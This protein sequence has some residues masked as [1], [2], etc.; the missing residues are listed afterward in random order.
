MSKV[1]IM[2][3]WSQ[4]QVAFAC[5]ASDYETVQLTL[6]N[7]VEDGAETST[8]YA[9]AHL[10]SVHDINE[11]S[12]IRPEEHPQ[13]KC[14][15]CAVCF[16]YLHALTWR[17]SDRFRMT[18][19]PLDVAVSLQFAIEHDFITEQRLET[20]YPGAVDMARSL[21][22]AYD[23]MRVLGQKNW[24]YAERQIGIVYPADLQ[25]DVCPYN[26]EGF[27][28]L[29]LFVSK[30]FAD[31]VGDEVLRDCDEVSDVDS[32]LVYSIYQGPDIYLSGV[33][34]VSFE[35]NLE[36]LSDLFR[37]V[38]FDEEMPSVRIYQPDQAELLSPE[39]SEWMLAMLAR[40]SWGV[41]YA[42]MVDEKIEDRSPV[43]RTCDHAGSV[44]EIKEN[45][46]YDNSEEDDY[47]QPDSAA[48]YSSSDDRQGLTPVR[49]R[50]RA[51]SLP[52]ATSNVYQVL[53]VSEASID[54]EDLDSSTAESKPEG[55]LQSMFSTVKRRL[56]TVV[57]EKKK[58]E[59]A[60]DVQFQLK[61]AQDKL[62]AEEER[63]ANLRKK[64][65]EAEHEDTKRARTRQIAVKNA[66]DGWKKIWTGD[67]NPVPVTYVN[68][69]W[70]IL[71]KYTGFTVYKRTQNQALASFMEALY[72]TFTGFTFLL[73]GPWFIVWQFG[74][75]LTTTAIISA[76]FNGWSFFWNL[77]DY[78]YEFYSVVDIVFSLPGKLRAYYYVR[79]IYRNE[80]LK[81]AL[82]L[83]TSI[84]AIFVGLWL[85][86][87]YREQKKKP[88]EVDAP[89]EQSYA[90]H[91][92][93]ASKDTIISRS[94]LMTFLI[95]CASLLAFQDLSIVRKTREY[96]TFFTNAAIVTNGIEESC[97]SSQCK[98][99]QR[100]DELCSR[101]RVN[102]ATE[103]FL[104]RV[105]VNDSVKRISKNPLQY[106]E[107]LF[108]DIH[109]GRSIKW[110]QRLPLGS[111]V[112]ILANYGLTPLDL[113]SLRY[114]IV[115][116]PE[117]QD[118]IWVFPKRAS[119]P[120]F[121]DENVL[122]QITVGE[123]VMAKSSVA[124]VNKDDIPTY[125]DAMAYVFQKD[126]KEIIPGDI[127]VML[128]AEEIFINNFRSLNFGPYWTIENENFVFAYPIITVDPE[129][130]YVARLKRQVD[131]IPFIG[132][133]F[134]Q[135]LCTAFVVAVLYIALFKINS[136]NS[137][138]DLFWSKLGYEKILSSERTKRDETALNTKDKKNFP[139]PE[140]E[141]RGVQ[142]S[143]Q[144]AHDK[145]VGFNTT[146]QQHFRQEA[147][148]GKPLRPVLREREGDVYV[149]RE[150][151]L[152]VY[153][154]PIKIINSVQG[155]PM[156]SKTGAIVYAKSS[157]EKAELKKKGYFPAFKSLSEKQAP[158]KWAMPKELKKSTEPLVNAT[159]DFYRGSNKIYT[160]QVRGS[161]LAEIRDEQAKY[162]AANPMPPII[163]EAYDILAKPVNSTERIHLADAFR[164]KWNVVAKD[165]SAKLP[166]KALSQ[167]RKV[168]SLDESNVK[169][170][171]SEY[172][173]TGIC[174]YEAR[175]D[176][177]CN[178]NHE[179]SSFSKG[180]ITRGKKMDLKKNES[181]L[182]KPKHQVLKTRAMFRFDVIHEGKVKPIGQAFFNGS[183]FVT[184]KHLFDVGEE[185]FVYDMAKQCSYPV[186]EM[187][188]ITNHICN[189][190]TCPHACK[191]ND[192]CKLVL[193]I[194][195]AR[196]VELKKNEDYMKINVGANLKAGDEIVMGWIDL[197]TN[198]PQMKNGRLEKVAE[199]YLLSDIPSEFG[200]SGALLMDSVTG[201]VIGLHKGSWDK[202]TN[203]HVRF[204]LKTIQM[205]NNQA[206][207]KA[208]K[209]VNTSK[210]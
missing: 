176:K 1:F 159:S 101:C 6:M 127:R 72:M 146:G 178:F 161:D 34:G 140:D 25:C 44:E 173:S 8:P 168:V 11:S 46:E 79:K 106:C 93:L 116:D 137:A 88:A 82:I 36:G 203:R 138:V 198:E 153:D 154:E 38:Q 2:K 126:A 187:I 61:K 169:R 124:E 75:F 130:S 33:S 22:V 201:H 17:A 180:V 37:E 167:Q 117:E 48:S 40:D 59:S 86:R 51:N 7:V 99:Q 196:L 54:D 64:L 160:M 55:R 136:V 125:Q 120:D 142:G 121:D 170:D 139:A 118:R 73:F 133:W 77:F 143:R 145:K 5:V 148:G 87:A 197:E 53:N 122:E 193:D 3:A 172:L 19:L 41:D 31:S 81:K 21:R 103:T 165:E 84:S 27:I 134:N 68:S 181:R 70:E 67:Q 98:I 71:K 128:K 114:K 15:V 210:D 115:Q 192:M 80:T 100:G 208:P 52:I 69:L 104:E 182:G 171:C 110:F 206:S 78:E 105:P 92:W 111:R 135:I 89:A 42:S 62:R 150:A 49:S 183:T 85:L 102:C 39:C 29:N 20:D 32:E 9:I 50:S 26:E 14:G 204:S 195:T 189:E 35:D 186:V 188:E 132:P 30:P 113:T 23:A 209:N 18:P 96:L 60:K 166:V 109:E 94:R 191:L 147:Q 91:N 174:D 63:V 184:V 185:F 164:V 123:M 194:P 175:V 4:M 162:N 112:T 199:D 74:V 16:Q 119:W 207:T 177:P 131:R 57:K 10:S 108:A 200:Y 58:E 202:E 155:F 47:E 45:E 149:K 129:L 179:G 95:G 158:A 156:I 24:T 97:S 66:I 76:M 43:D 83:G 163:K 144:Q 205:I 65:D 28:N 141:G 151:Y 157:K 107:R 190:N 12:I 56:G 90:D 152:C 13:A